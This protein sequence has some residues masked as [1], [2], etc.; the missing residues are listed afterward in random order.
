MNIIVK[1][2]QDAMYIIPEE[3]LIEVFTPNHNN[4]R[5]PAESLEQSIITNVI[6]ARVV[7]DANIAKGEHMLIKLGDL[8]PKYIE[9][10]RCIYEIPESKLLGKTILSV[11]SV[12]YTPFSGGIGSFGY[13]YGGVGPMFTQDVM[14]AA[15]QM[16]EAS[17]AI[18]NVAT[19]KV[20]LIGEN[21][22]L[23]EDA[24]RYNTAYYLN[25]YVTDNNYLNKIDPRS[26]EYFST[27]CEYAIKAHVYRKM[28]IRL[29]RGRI[30]GGSMIGEF[31]AV[32]DE[33]AD[34]ETNYRTFLKEKWA[35]QAFMD[36][37]RR[38]YNFIKAQIP[39]G[40]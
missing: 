3:I 1:A 40:L 17:S 39:I 13:A 27:L 26:F 33:Y 37:S 10:Y 11:L 35:K 31:K 6:Q 2:V 7:P 9:D 32:I 29:D 36:N 34:A 21:T 24:Q 4:Y 15:Q 14:T 25:C 16:V 20:E 5:A 28:R 22:I 30:E 38:Y 8:Q 12:S 18:P 23:I 19:A